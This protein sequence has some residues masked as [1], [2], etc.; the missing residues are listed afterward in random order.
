MRVLLV[1]DD[2][3]VMMITTKH[4]ESLGYEVVQTYDGESALKT[5]N[6]E[7]MDL[8]FMDYMLPGISGFE[9]TRLLRRFFS[10]KWFPIIFLTSSSGDNHL[11]E[12]LA[13]GGDD[14]LHKPVSSLVLEAKIKAFSRIVKIQQDLI[15]AN[16]KMEQL[17]FLDGL[18]E[19]YNRRGFNRA[20]GRE[21]RRMKRDNNNLS[22]LMIDVDFFKKYN[23]HYGHLA[24][25]QCLKCIAFALDENVYRPA[26]TVARY[27]GE[28]FAIL[29]PDT[30]QKGAT[31]IAS[32]L[33]KAVEGIKQE[34]IHS[35]VSDCTTISIGVATS[36]KKVN[37]SIKKLIN[38]ADNG[39]YK[40]KSSGRNCYATC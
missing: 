20:L 35:E 14:Y 23:D 32:R 33:L 37:N 15:N 3:S 10:D 8:I 21:W 24:G 6:P 4:I 18:T 17:S 25:D 16:R 29:L 30:G 12:G 2:P 9:T 7:S 39:L 13:A 1:E 26:D 28:E 36:G 27:G 34:H 40:A 11:A 22:L 31:L 5:F 19:V 38:A